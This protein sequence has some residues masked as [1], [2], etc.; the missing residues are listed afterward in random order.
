MLVAGWAVLPPDDGRRQSD[1]VRTENEAARRTQCQRGVSRRKSGWEVSAIRSERQ[2][3]RVAGCGAGAAPAA[4][5]LDSS[6]AGPTA[7]VVGDPLR[8]VLC[9]ALAYS[10]GPGKRVT[11]ADVDAATWSG[12]KAAAASGTPR[13]FVIDQ[14]DSTDPALVSPVT[15]WTAGQ[16]GPAQFVVSWG[17][18]G[19]PISAWGPATGARRLD[20]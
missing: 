11:A 2:A 10:I 8:R 1:R 3:T 5:A 19:F 6:R 17:R 9:D 18:P 15:S 14:P 4:G 13:M 20:F 7:A 16:H 12:L